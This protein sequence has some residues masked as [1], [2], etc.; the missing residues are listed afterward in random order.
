VKI[1]QVEPILVSIPFQHGAP[2]PTQG[3]GALGKLDILLVRVA[4]DEGIT[5][6]GEAFGHAST[7][8]TIAALRRIVAPLAVGRDPQPIPALM[9]ELW[10]RTQSMS[11][12]GPV[13]YALSG[14][15]IAL[16]D[17]AGKIA[18]QPV[19]QLLG[20]RARQRIPAY[21]SLLRIGDPDDVAR[22]AAAAAGR[23]YRQIKLHEHS[24]A[25]VAAARRAVGPEVALMIDTNCHWTSIADAAAAAAAFAPH[26]PAWLE[27]PL[28]P[29]E[30]F[31]A[32]AHLRSQI[33]I[34]IAGGEN[35]GNV[36]EL[37]RMAERAVDI[38]QP[39]IAKMGGISEIRKLVGGRVQGS[40]RVV[41]HAPFSG[42]ALAAVIHVIA[43][44]SQDVAC[45][46]RYCDLEASPIG[47]WLLAR[48]GELRVPTGPGLGVE[49]DPALIARYRVE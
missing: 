23:G 10:R 18:R 31:E 45:E 6:W 8:I 22:V 25:A 28:F 12:N 35:L 48:D 14:L 13:A 41:P 47:D 30:D 42:P 49:I 3:P 44:M 37:G 32:L 4:T 29:P 38:L 21:A 34:P 17:I 7:P 16:W 33:A 36:G 11:R 9:T 20:G 2:F 15:D 5:G 27:E 1:T 39:S 46:H 19:W 24:A 40:V 26:Q 43:A